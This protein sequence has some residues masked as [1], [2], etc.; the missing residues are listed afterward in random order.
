MNTWAILTMEYNTVT[1]RCSRYVRKNYRL[2]LLFIILKELDVLTQFKMNHRQNLS[3][4]ETALH[5]GEMGSRN[6]P[7]LHD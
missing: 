6:A 4:L 3:A 2:F 7:T 5:A 1:V